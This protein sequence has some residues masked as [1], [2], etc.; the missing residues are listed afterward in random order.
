MMYSLH[1]GVAL[2]QYSIPA[3]F[4]ALLVSTYDLSDNREKIR[5]ALFAALAASFKPQVGAIAFLYGAVMLQISFLLLAALIYTAVFSIGLIPILLVAGLDWI[6]QLLTNISLV[7]ALQQDIY[8]CINLKPVLLHV[9]SGPVLSAMQ[10]L[11]L[12][13]FL[14][15][16]A[17]RYVNGRGSA[18]RGEDMLRWRLIAFLLCAAMVQLSIYTRPYNLVLLAP[19]LLLYPYLARRRSRA[20]VLALF[21]AMAIFLQPIPVH[22]VFALVVG[23]VYQTWSDLGRKIWSLLVAPIPTYALVAV[24]LSLIGI[25]L[26][27]PSGLYQKTD[28]A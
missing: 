10:L 6:D 1:T 26:R 22:G 18:L 16:L 19:V 13:L 4:C 9:A 25:A 2:L 17:L 3:I 21:G 11:P 14:G 24:Y 20:A 7:S 27:E 12:A 23:E 5:A 8:C 28:D 15:V